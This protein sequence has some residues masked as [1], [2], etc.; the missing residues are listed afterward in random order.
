MSKELHFYDLGTS[1][2]VFKR[3][4]K[5]L[6]EICSIPLMKD[7]KIPFKELIYFLYILGFKIT[8][9]KV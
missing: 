6:V 3:T 1:C 9:R 7:R 8:I 2:K 5:R 4:K